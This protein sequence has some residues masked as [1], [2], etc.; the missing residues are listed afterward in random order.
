MMNAAYV[1]AVRANDFKFAIESME[2]RNKA[3]PDQKVDGL[4]KIGTVQYNFMKDEASALTSF[5]AAYEAS[6]KN[7]TTLA[8]IPQPLQAKL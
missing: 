4:I 2:V 7:S 1:L 5:K 3:Y 6:G 8:Q